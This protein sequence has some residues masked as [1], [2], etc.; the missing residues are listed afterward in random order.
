MT[1]T[2]L[3][4]Q[5]DDSIMYGFYY[6]AFIEYILARQTLLDFTNLF[7]PNDYKKNGKIII[8]TLKTNM[9]EEENLN[10]RLK[11]RLNKKLC[12]VRNKIY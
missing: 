11:N 1:Y 12:F 9:T 2:I 4:T 10:F 5:D 6:I 7:S 8:N 3:R